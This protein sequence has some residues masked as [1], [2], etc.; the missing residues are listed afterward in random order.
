[1]QIEILKLVMWLTKS[2]F[3]LFLIELISLQLLVANNTEAQS[4]KEVK[5]S[6][7]LF[8]ATPGQFFAAIEER[9]DFQFVHN[10]SVSKVTHPI[11]YYSKD[12]TL[13][14]VLLYAAR[15]WGLQFRRINQTISVSRAPKKQED[16][17]KVL[18][19]DRTI[20]GKVTDSETG[21][22]L[23]GATIQMKG[24]SIGT[25]TDIDGN[26]KLAVPDDIEE[27]QISYIG[28]ESKYLGVGAQTLF[29]ITLS[30]EKAT[31]S[32]VV[33]VGYS[34]EKPKDFT[35]SISSVNGNQVNQLPVNG[36][37][38][39]LQGQVAGV[40]V[41]SN[42]APGS[43]TSVRIR[44][45]GTLGN[46]DPLYIV[47]G[48]PTRFGLNQFSNADI[49][50]IQVLKDAAATA[51]Y[52]ARAAN[53]VVIINTKHGNIG[54][55]KVNANFQFGVQAPVNLPSMVNTEQY[56]NM[57]WQAQINSGVKPTN[58]LFGDG[59]QPIIPEFIDEEEKIRAS[60][61]GT[62]W[63]NELFDP[64]P[65]QSYNISVASGKKGIKNYTSFSYLD[66]DG[67]MAYTGFTKYNFR[68]NTE[69]SQGILTVGEN[70]SLS[71]TN[72]QSVP[73]NRALG[74]RMIHAYRINPIVPVRDI[75]GNF[76]GP[77]NGVQGALNPIGINALD[78]NDRTIENRLFGNVYAAIEIIKG[79]NFK[80]NF[81]FDYSDIN[82]KDYDFRYQMGVTNRGE[83]SFFQAE[84]SR[85][86]YTINNILQFKRKIGFHDFSFLL[87]QEAIK[88][89][90]N[91]IGGTSSNFVTDDIDFI[92]LNTGTGQSSNFSSGS[93]WALSSYFTRVNYQFNDKYLLSASMRRD[94]SSRF[95][96]SNRFALFPALSAGWRLTEESFLKDQSLFNE[97]KL[98]FSFGQSGNQEIGDFPSF[99]TFSA[100]AWDTYY[101]IN[102][103]NDKATIGFK[104][105]RIGNDKVKWE[106][107]QQINFGLDIG[108]YKGLILNFDYFIK[109]T[110]DI[111]I[112]RPTLAIEGQAAAPFVNLGNMQNKGLELNL[113]YR[114]GAGKDWSLGL[115]GNLSIVRNKVVKL[116]D[117][118]AQLTGLASNTYSRNLIL[119]VTEVGQP[120]AQFYG[121]IADG[122]FKTQQD[123]QSHADQ[124][125]KAIGRIRYRDLNDDGVVDSND[126]TFIGN[127]H[128]DF[129]YGFTLSASY[130]SFDLS[131]LLQGVQGVDL[132]NF[133][134]YYTD[135][136]YD[137]GNRH[138]RILDAWTP[139]NSDSNIPSLS[140]VDTNN[141]LRPS[142]YFIED[143]SYLRIKNIRVGYQIPL[144]RKI[145]DRIYSYVQVQNL[146]TFTKYEG[147]DPEVGLVNNTDPERN[148]D[149]GVDRGVYPNPRIVLVGLN[150]TI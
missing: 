81:G 111:L 101:S 6:L 92:Q 95:S 73:T 32:E 121:H 114:Y 78:A 135:F 30:V 93:E 105:T 49:D 112:Q 87:G 84:A 97:L 137:L 15:E 108:F 37:E 120:I 22:P 69:V 29:N 66:Q 34:S 136:Y 140:A 109:E 132:Y 18:E 76:A 21:E 59:P 50:N 20:T 47:D 5:V 94:G 55:L 98:R 51:I 25:V 44:G 133:T 149:I 9:T 74:S 58:D 19:L 61:P 107:T 118:V 104:P 116:A 71:S 86:Q 96:K 127:P 26:F 24:T 99:S 146:F 60:V 23:I 56:A 100:S 125:G 89:N 148:L 123:V 144:A 7:N 102:G 16:S 129:I 46:N 128:P 14:N 80:S 145:F 115:N 122:I 79:L 8:D 28:Y 39:A 142:T 12:E 67:I 91:E 4:L 43:G 113:E 57:L 48:I 13:E 38:Q 130:S 68:T 119:S 2:A 85:F 45:Y 83:T 31:M 33:V 110:Y 52:G 88:F 143:G 77:V 36:I 72:T 41:T 117:D 138:D 62:D 64:A 65:F 134:R 150:I 42:G 103:S 40:Q 27:I 53:G 106:T 139:S 54:N 141:E 126:R 11:S 147:I 90:T 75:K 124:D 35:G 1:M 3:Y 63:F 70:L 82:T 131:I 10:R 17:Q